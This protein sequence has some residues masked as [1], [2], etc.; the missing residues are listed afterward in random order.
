MHTGSSFC[1]TSFCKRLDFY[2]ES[3]AIESKFNLVPV[4]GMKADD[5]NNR[6][7]LSGVGTDGLNLN[8][9]G[10]AVAVPTTVPMTML[11][12]FVMRKFKE[13]A[14]HRMMSGIDAKLLE[15]IQSARHVYS[16][17]EKARFREANLPDDIYTPLCAT[18]IRAALA[19]LTE[20]F[21][22]PGDKPWCLA[23]TPLA[24]VP[25][26]VIQDAWMSVVKDFMVLVQMGGTPPTE[27]QASAYAFNR[28]DEVLRKQQEWAKVR[29]E[30]MERKVYDQMIEGGWIE[31]FQEYCQYISVYGTGVIR[32]P[33]P[34]V[35]LRKETYEDGKYKTIKC[36]M[37]P[38]EVLCYDA[39]NPWDCY[40]S[41][42]AKNIKQ[43]CLCIRTRY[44]ASDLW[45]FASGKPKESHEDG[46]WMVD[47][48]NAILQQHPDGGVR[49]ESQSYDLLRRIYEDN[50]VPDS[51]DCTL[52]GIDFY[53]TIRGSMLLELGI[54]KTQSE[55][56]IDDK[57]YYEVN[58]ICIAGYIVYCKIIDPRIRRPLSKGVFYKNPDSWWGDCIS[59]KLNATQRVLNCALR[60]L[61]NNMAMTSG[62]QIYLTD[63]DRLRNKGPDA[64]KLKPFKVWQFNMGGYAQNGLPIG[65]FD[66]P[67]HI[68][69]LLKVFEWAKQQADDDSGI[70]AY[71]YGANVGGGAGRTA[72][73]LAMLTEA[74]NR[75]MKM[76]VTSTDMDVIRDVVRRT[77]DFNMVYDSD[78]SIKGDC[79][80]NPSGVMG[81]ILKEQESNR[82]K[83][84]LGTLMNPVGM[85]IFGP[86]PVVELA[87]EEFKSLGLKNVDDL[88]PS[89]E[90]QEFLE[91]VAQMQQYNQAMQPQLQAQ[92]EGQPPAEGTNPTLGG[93]EQAGAVNQQIQENPQGFA[94]ERGEVAQRRG[95][96]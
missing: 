52:E 48:V 55:E 61:V 40:P 92:A 72:S 17:E 73:G 29:A 65:S 88:I 57:K 51:E 26:S 20:I 53:G 33:I 35:M 21:T 38:K 23:P 76:V 70:P 45:Q 49:L 10:G 7:G 14:D 5:E 11:A 43:G 91:M 80:V 64:M 66:I 3:M 25:E 54:S 27:E 41:K 47:T 1:A 85:Q 36:R 32:G 58:A 69:E 4:N 94:E 24:D 13:N 15:C 89:K 75:G 12:S 87:R 62:P 83:Q 44:S 84:M 93:S 39:V 34:R 50:G 28:M 22:S 2:T 56:K 67:S 74:A 42:G 82:R 78:S 81:L 16:P 8:G 60:N 71:T 9:Y 86:K 79:E 90:K 77:V 30:R 63:A 6:G 95:A 37:V 59:N 18:K 31:A 46:E 96:A 68:P 19:Q